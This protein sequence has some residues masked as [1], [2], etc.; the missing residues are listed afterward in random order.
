MSFCFNY[1]KKEIEENYFLKKYKLG[2]YKELEV[3]KI[4]FINK[5]SVNDEKL[6]FTNKLQRI[7]SPRIN[8]I[9]NVITDLSFN[10]NVLNDCFNGEEINLKTLADLKKLD[11]V[12]K[13]L[14]LY[15]NQPNNTTVYKYAPNSNYY[16]KYNA[17]EYERGFQL[18][19]THNNNEVNI[20]LIDLYHLVILSKKQDLID[21]YEKRKKYKK[22]IAECIF[23]VDGELASN[24]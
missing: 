3:N 11:R 9:K 16:K 5:Y 23:S 18:L 10:T 15:D 4:N 2:K 12:D 24:R 14:K 7:N 22:D 21:E 13:I 8:A 19:F 1:E 20:Y 17:G 6:C